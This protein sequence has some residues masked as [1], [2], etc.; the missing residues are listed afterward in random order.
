MINYI[1][2][3][4]QDIMIRYLRNSYSQEGEDIILAR[5]FENID[6]GYY[7]DI[8][9]HHPF[10]FSNTYYFYKK[11]WK[12]INVDAMPGSMNVF[13]DIRPKDINLEFAVSTTSEN[14]IFHIFN[15]PA[16][17]TFD[18]DLAKSRVNN[19]HLVTNRIE[20]E[21]VTLEFILEKY[22]PINQ[23]INFLT[24]DVEG[25]DYEVLQ[26][27]NWNKYRPNCVLIEIGDFYN[28]QLCIKNKINIL[29]DNL[30]YT[31][32]AKTVNTAFYLDR[33]YLSNNTI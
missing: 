10:R 6:T 23:N 28:I 12:G 33:S 30:G 5:I 15:D 26:S 4:I 27:N 21:T 19:I 8:G 16:L 13:N 31:F 32:F 17:N 1:K 25:L 22:L 3:Q 14:N 29:L 20:I 9:A 11:N 18:I 24:I 7:V 2:K